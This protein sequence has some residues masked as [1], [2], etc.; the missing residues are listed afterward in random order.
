MPQDDKSYKDLITFVE[1]RAGHDRRYAID[2]TKITS[3]LGWRPVYTFEKGIRKT[4]EWYLDNTKWIESIVSGDYVK[5]YERMYVESNL[6]KNN[7]LI[8]VE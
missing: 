6:K 8:M 1:D 5:Y 3:E 2:N 7:N 4:I